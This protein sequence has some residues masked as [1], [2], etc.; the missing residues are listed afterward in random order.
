MAI[1]KFT[2]RK[3]PT[4]D[5]LKSIEKGKLTWFD[6]EMFSNF[7]TRVMEEY[8]EEK[9]RIGGF[10]KSIFFWRK[11]VIGIIIGMCFAVINQY[12]GLKIGL[13]VGGSWYIM[14]LIGLV[15]RWK[16]TE[17]NI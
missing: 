6:P 2:Y 12:I 10:E 14:Y 7:N 1:K 9:N 17:I 13:V 15:L 16:P 11:I 3:P 4:A 8:F 5:G